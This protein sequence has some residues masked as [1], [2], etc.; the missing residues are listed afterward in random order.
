M[1]DLVCVAGMNPKFLCETLNLPQLQVLF[2]QHKG[3][4]TKNLIN[5]LDSFW[6]LF[7]E[8][9]DAS[10]AL[11]SEF[12]EGLEGTCT[13]FKIVKAISVITKLMA[14][15]EFTNHPADYLSAVREGLAEYKFETDPGNPLFKR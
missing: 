10:K 4:L 11:V 14:Q 5:E 6:R 8:Q 2:Q 15:P 9:P 1:I 12:I 7:H 3:Q 13:V